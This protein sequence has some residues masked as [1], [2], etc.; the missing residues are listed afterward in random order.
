MTAYK[1][2]RVNLF[3]IFSSEFLFINFNYILSAILQV[4]Y[5]VI[6]TIVSDG[7]IGKIMEKN[8]DV[9]SSTTNQ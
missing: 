9:L 7:E 5:N 8:V 2:P 1:T 3:Q 6:T 4:I